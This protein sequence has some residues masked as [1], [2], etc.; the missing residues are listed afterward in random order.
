M[1]KLNLTDKKN[2]KSFSK[3]ELIKKPSVRGHHSNYSVFQNKNKNYFSDKKTK[4][5]E[6]LSMIYSHCDL[7]V[8]ISNKNSYEQ[9]NSRTVNEVY[10]HSN[11][12]SQES[13]EKKVGSYA[14]SSGL[15]FIENSRIVNFVE[16]GPGKK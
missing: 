1:A 11:F 5:F 15:A 4:K 7:E 14:S 2:P 13:L 16:L 12:N 6:T 3:I 9:Q 8:K 10:P